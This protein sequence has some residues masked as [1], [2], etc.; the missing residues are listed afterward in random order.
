MNNYDEKKFNTLL[1]LAEL[2]L[3]YPKTILENYVK[4]Q[5]NQ[6]KKN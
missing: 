6:L 3:F 4:K 1:E 5:L 2:E